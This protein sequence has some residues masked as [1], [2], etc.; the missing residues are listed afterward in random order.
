MLLLVVVVQLGFSA[1][2]FFPKNDSGNHF[3]VDKELQKQIDT[4]K[5]KAIQQNVLKIFP[6]NPN[7]ISDFKG[8]ELGMS[9]VE[10]D[11]LHE[12]RAL[13]NYV[14]SS[15]EFQKVTQVSDSLLNEIAPYFK[16]PEWT[17]NRKHIVKTVKPK[18]LKLSKNSSKLFSKKVWSN[19][20]DASAED[21]K[22]V[23]GIG[24]VLSRRIIKF[25]DHL[26]GFLVNE[27]LYHV[28][29]VDSLV[30]SKILDKFVV[31]N[32]PEIKK[33][34]VTWASYN[35]LRNLLYINDK[36][37]NSIIEYRNEN[38]INSLSE[39]RRLEGCPIEKF[40]VLKLYLSF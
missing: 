35:E 26:G 38:K 31:E 21:L 12:F 6:F 20:N 22:V 33:I 18:G 23:R 37:A 36:F 39:L 13:N 10:I 25:R 19:I 1:L 5:Q 11:R 32:P 27:Q 34:N 17:K 29:G 2:R 28:Y 30:V 14:N 7:Y 3:L 4:L 9:V 40:Q 16:F 15:E 8:Y 24:D